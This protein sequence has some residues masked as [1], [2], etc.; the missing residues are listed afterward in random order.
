MRNDT[1]F[2]T[3]KK[4]KEKAKFTVENRKGIFVEMTSLH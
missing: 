2:K 4:E 1:Y 3:R